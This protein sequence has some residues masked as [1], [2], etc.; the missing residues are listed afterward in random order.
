MMHEIGKGRYDNAYKN[1]SPKSTDIVLC[2]KDRDIIVKENSDEISFL[3]YGKVLSQA[4]DIAQNY[5]YLFKIDDTSY[6]LIPQTENIELENTRRIYIRPFRE[7]AP[8]TNVFAG[9]TGFQLR[10]WYNTRKYCSSCGKPLVHDTKERMLRCTD[11]GHMEYPK[12]CPA[13]R[14]GVISNDR[15]LLTTYARGEH[16]RYGLVAGFAEIG[17]TIEETVVREVMEETGLRVSR[18]KYYKSQP[19]SLTDTLLFGFWAEIDGD[20][21]V[22]LDE[23]ELASAQWFS[24]NDVVD[25]NSISLTGEMMRVFKEGAKIFD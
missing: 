2:Y 16:T 24:R 9:M 7:M 18:V 22:F 13:V 17:E 20:D 12:I 11:C 21:A 6:F 5:I 8:L 19:W 3:T 10:N 14:V 25:E 23:E 1:I 4:P 15:I